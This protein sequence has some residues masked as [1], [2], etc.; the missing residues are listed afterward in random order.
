MYINYNTVNGIEYGTVTNSVRNG[1]KVGKGDQIYLGRVIDK[2][3]GIFKN[4][5]RGLFV[6]DLENNSYSPVPADY[7]MPKLERKTKYPK[8]PTLIVSFG[9]IFLLDE[10]LKKSGLMNAVDAI[11]YKN[12]DTLHA[13]LTYYILT[14]Y[15]N[16][17]AEDW[18]ELTYAKYLYPKAQ[19]ESQ[20]I[21]D[22]LADIGSEEAKRNFFKKYFRFLEKRTDTTKGID[23]GVLID[24]SGL[25][26]SIHFPL[27]AINNHNGVISEELRLIYVVQQHTGMPFFFRY[28]AG[29]VID[30][31]TITRTIAELKANGVNTKFAILDAGYYTSKNA[32][33][34]LDAGV[35]FM[36]RMKSNFK[37]YQNAIK[38]HLGSLVSKDNAVIYNNRL[39]Y[40]KLIPCKIGQKENR[41]AY[42]YLCKD[43]AM[44]NEGQKHA[45]ERAGDEGLS[46][47]DIFDDLQKQGVFVLITTRKVGTDKLLP[48]YYMRD[49]VEK[50]FE[51]CK[52]GEKILPIN[53]EKEETLRG[54]LM[55]TF[56]ASVTLKM[57]SDKL[58]K[59]AL[60]TESMFMNLHEQHAIVYDNEFITTE[61]VK[62]MNEAYKAFKVQCPAT[63]PR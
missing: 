22:A 13:L 6:Y 18:W 54:H 2:E 12:L 39:V 31:S 60:T 36:A 4:R 42:A 48:L 57:M 9:D 59:T 15:A 34:L 23:D 3:K 11:A 30:V 49:Q 27:T 29:N 38:E 63:I 21:S 28:V 37:A 47:A 40:I 55:L 53:V 32:D 45:L 16:C 33:A 5:K 52:Q 20:R 43:M 56:I 50:I 25:P 7:E 46:G 51:L 19:M 8:R 58:K 41:P 17:H 44:H 1:A 26:N 61:P 24:S 14:S 35:S 10:F 62:K